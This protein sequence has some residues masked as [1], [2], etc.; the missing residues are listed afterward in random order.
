MTATRFGLAP[1]PRAPTPIRGALG[2]APRPD[3]LGPPVPLLSAK[4][5]RDWPPKIGAPKNLVFSGGRAM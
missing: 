2:M 5:A 3:T 1:G 4:A